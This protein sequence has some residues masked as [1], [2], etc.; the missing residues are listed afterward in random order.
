MKQIQLHNSWSVAMIDDEDFELVNAYKWRVGDK[1]VKYAITDIKVDGKY[2]TVRMHRLI[3]GA[4]KGEQI[5]H[6]DHNGLNNQKHNLRICTHAEN[7]KNRRSYGSS[8]YL[9]VHKFEYSRT[10]KRK[11][12]TVTY[13]YWRARIKSGEKYISLG[14][15]KN[16]EDAARAYD[17]AATELHGEFANLNFKDEAFGKGMIIDKKTLK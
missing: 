8:K 9:G 1:K 12:N 6:K 14:T 4:K 2:K 5:D 16:E 3:M 13:S 11:G 7:S 15:H 17:K 10:F